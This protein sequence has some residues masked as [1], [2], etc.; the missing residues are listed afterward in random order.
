MYKKCVWCYDDYEFEQE[1][2]RKGVVNEKGA[3]QVM[4]TTINSSSLK[5]LALHFIR[6]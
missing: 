6:S 1:M 2:Q 5:A 4:Q 3:A